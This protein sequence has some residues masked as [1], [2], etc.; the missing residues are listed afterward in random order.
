[1]IYSN[2]PSNLNQVFDAQVKDA[3]GQIAKDPKFPAL[4]ISKYQFQASVAKVCFGRSGFI[5]D[6]ESSFAN[7]KIQ[8]Q[9]STTLILIQKQLK[10]GKNFSKPITLCQKLDPSVNPKLKIAPPKKK[11]LPKGKPKPKDKKPLASKPIKSFFQEIC[12]RMDGEQEIMQQTINNAM[13]NFANNVEKQQ[14][15]EEKSINLGV[16]LIV[17]GGVAIALALKK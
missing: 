14:V 3:N 13:S 8:P 15:I 5:L 6:Q 2:N 16:P 7:F 1:M 17:L 12:S 9:S 10:L 4:Q 11:E